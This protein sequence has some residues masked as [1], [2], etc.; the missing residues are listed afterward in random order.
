M[1]IDPSAVGKTGGPVN[2]KW[3]SKDALL[4]AVGVGAG[5]NDLPFVTE[6]SKDIPQRVLP[7]FA[8]IIGFIT[9]SLGMVWPWKQTIYDLHPDYKT[10]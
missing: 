8:V 3:T 5:T 7:T 4:Y 10:L 9:G 2:Y 6:N 1:P